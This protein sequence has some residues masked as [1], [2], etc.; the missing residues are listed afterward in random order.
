MIAPSRLPPPV[1][2]K[3]EIEL[4]LLAAAG[5]ITSTV[6]RGSVAVGDALREMRCG[7]RES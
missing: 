3:Q 5:T 4:L 6:L 1:A 2:Q 7:S